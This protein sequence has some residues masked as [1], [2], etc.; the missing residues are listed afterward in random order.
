MSI[1]SDIKNTLGDLL[2]PLRNYLTD[3]IADL[4]DVLL[5]ATDKVK[6]FVSDQLGYIE[7][8]IKQS[9]TLVKNY[10]SGQLKDLSNVVSGGTTGIKS[11]IQK[12]LDIEMGDIIDTYKEV[13]EYLAEGFKEV[14]EDIE[15]SNE[16]IGRYFK[17]GLTVLAE[18]VAEIPQT[19]ERLMRDGFETIAKLPDILKGFQEA[20]FNK[21][22]DLLT[23]T[24]EDVVEIAKKFKDTQDK[25][26]KGM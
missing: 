20:I 21:L 22:D 7:T 6:G 15:A 19:L 9:Q 18:I 4:G 13:K 12:L 5:G 1:L 16:A 11:F 23:F 25:I 2:Y 24:E 17:Q 26:A 3:K 8:G 14:G 10:L